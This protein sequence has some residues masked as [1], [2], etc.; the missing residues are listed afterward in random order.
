[1]NKCFRKSGAIEPPHFLSPYLEI[2]AVQQHQIL[3]IDML[4]KTWC[5]QTVSPY[6]RFSNDT[7]ISFAI[8]IMIY[9]CHPCVIPAE[10]RKGRFDV[11]ARHYDLLLCVR[12]KWRFDSTRF[13]TRID[14]RKFGAIKPPHLV[15]YLNESLREFHRYVIISKTKTSRLRARVEPDPHPGA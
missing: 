6:L 10:D 8:N 12:T 15:L 1:M 14:F 11:L 7:L 2:T 5:H 3:K 9:P 13:S 4:H